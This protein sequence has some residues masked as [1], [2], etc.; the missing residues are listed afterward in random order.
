V[1]NTF[2]LTGVFEGKTVGEISEAVEAEGRYTE[3]RDLLNEA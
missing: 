1:A 3:L 2:A